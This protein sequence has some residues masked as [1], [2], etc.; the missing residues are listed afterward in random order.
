MAAQRVFA[1]RGL[2]N[3]KVSDIVE[4]AGLAQGTFYLYFDSKHD[5][6]DAVAEQMVDGMVEAIEQAVRSTDAGAVAKVLALRDAMLAIA[7]DPAG[8]EIAEVYH[9]PE[10]RAVH[11][12]M[13]ERIASRLGPLVESMVT[14]GVAE[15]T[16][17]ADDPRVSAWFVLG[18]F[19]MLEVGFAERAHLP[20]AIRHATRC[21]LGALGYAGSTPAD[22]RR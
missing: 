13:A 10:N 19:H 11:D 18:G 14:Q 21:A 1:A 3:A 17:H 2:A 4:A 16:F 12:R 20:A 9:R 6:V 15:G 22:P 7:A 5:V 8:W